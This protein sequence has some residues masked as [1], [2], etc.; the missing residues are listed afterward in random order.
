MMNRN[1][2]C[3]RHY[4]ILWIAQIDQIIFRQPSAGLSCTWLILLMKVRYLR[5]TWSVYPLVIC[6][7]A[8]SDLENS[9]CHLLWFHHCNWS[10]ALWAIAFNIRASSRYIHSVKLKSFICHPWRFIQDIPADPT[11]CSSSTNSTDIKILRSHIWPG[12]W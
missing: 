11:E 2:L 3:S 9:Y 12:F 6:S 4:I 7:S 5:G 10:Q 1:H 8:W